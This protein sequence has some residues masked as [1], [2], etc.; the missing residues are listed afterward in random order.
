[1]VY[2]ILAACNTANINPAEYLADVF[3]KLPCRRTSEVDDLIPGRWSP[4]NNTI[5]DME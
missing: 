1:V 3:Q 4:Q 2:T 5:K